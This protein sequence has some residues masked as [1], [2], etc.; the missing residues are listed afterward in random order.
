MATSAVTSPTLL[1]DGVESDTT[2]APG[3]ATGTGWRMR[4]AVVAVLGAAL[5]LRTIGVTWH[6]PYVY[7]PDEPTNLTVVRGMLVRHSLDPRFFHYPSLFF[8]VYGSAYAAWYQ[9]GHAVGWFHSA[10]ALPRP[11]IQVL[12]DGFMRDYSPLIAVRLVSVFAGCATVG[13]GMVLCSLLTRRRAAI[14]LAGALIACNPIL[15]RNARWFT[16]DTLAGL[17]TMLALVAAVVVARA[18]DPRPRHY[19]F[20]GV[21]VG[22]AVSAKYNVALVAVALVVAHFVARRESGDALPARYLG[23][24]AAAAAAAFLI[25]SPYAVFDFHRFWTDF[26]FEIH[27]YNTGHLGSEGNSPG[28]NLN[29]VWASIGPALLIVL[30][31]RLLKPRVRRLCIV[32]L[33]FVILYFLA[34]SVPVV[35]F[36]RNLTPLLPPLLVVVAVIAVAAADRIRDLVR[37]Q[38]AAFALSACAL[39]V[40]V[41]W[42][43]LFSVRDARAALTDSRAGARNW[44]VDNVPAGSTVDVDGYSPLV[45]RHRFRVAARSF[46]VQNLD[47]IR[48]DDPDVV[49]A[50]ALGSGRYLYGNDRNPAMVSAFNAEI[51]SA[52]SV[53]MF[54]SGSQRIWVLR[55]HC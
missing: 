44:I 35:R 39:A 6:L 8:D 41:G 21:A 26:W 33:S 45:D 49:V 43:L 17:T 4:A 18:R 2:E 47:I 30:G 24:A 14:L 31:L 27:H 22:L 19:V 37:D 46:V 32:P 16:P 13:A 15:V 1:G 25:T 36:E 55:F 48:A 11:E 12:G 10:G 5:A 42:P 51:A 23:Y 20:A 40:V 50:T 34:I 54:G 53:A 38:R 9:F 3:S 52:C 29:W 7:H 28:T